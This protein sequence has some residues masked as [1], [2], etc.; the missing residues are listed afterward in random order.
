ML[1]VISVANHIEAP[2]GA[3]RRHVQ[4]VWFRNSPVASA[5]SC[6]VAPQY[7]Y[8]DRCLF[9]LHSVDGA[10]HHFAWEHALEVLLH[11]LERSDDRN[12]F[13]LYAIAM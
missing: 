5:R 8:D 13:R 2:L 11:S 6:R 4:Q 10:G 1:P 7:D 9:A 3:R 12:I